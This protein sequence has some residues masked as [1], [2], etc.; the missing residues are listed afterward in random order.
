MSFENGKVCCNCRHDIRTKDKGGDIKTTCDI[1]GSYIGYVKCMTF[2]CRR[3]SE[4]LTHQK[5]GRLEVVSVA[6][7]KEYKGKDGHISRKVFWLC[8]CDCGNNVRV[9]TE[10]LKKG[11]TKSCGC[12][13]KE[14]LLHQ[15]H[16]DT[17]TRLYRIWKGMKARCM[18]TTSQSYKWYG[19][20]GVSVCE[21][22]LSYEPFKKWAKENGYNDTLSIDRINPYGNY[23][24]SNCRWATN[25]EQ[26]NNH[27][28]DSNK[29]RIGQ[30]VI[31]IETD[32]QYISAMAASRKLGI[33]N[34]SILKVCKE[35]RKTA[36]G[37]TW[38]FA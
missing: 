25:K 4:D 33:D 17:H 7:V 36:G 24:P 5:Y 21:D 34:S 29:E 10:E 9:A 3:W 31:C 38:K 1:D 30:A 15:T 35:K 23:E 32:E 13:R 14:Y 11:Q 19:A 28:D 12:L 16:G 6:N 27:R 37:Y 18:I 8:K 2:S 26:R 22:W 20:K